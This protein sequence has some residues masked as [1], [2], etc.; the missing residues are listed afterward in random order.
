MCT[1]LGNLCVAS[2]STNL[3]EEESRNRIVEPRPRRTTADRTLRPQR[4]CYE[5][6]PKHTPI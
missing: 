2:Q 4:Q 5:V 3:L 1:V 6:S